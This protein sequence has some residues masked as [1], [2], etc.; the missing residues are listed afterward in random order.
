MRAPDFANIL[1]ILNRQ[2]PSRPTLFEFFLNPRLYGRMLGRKEIGSWGSV[3]HSRSV[4]AA[5]PRFGYDYATVLAC[6]L[7]FPTKPHDS[8]ASRS[9]NES[10]LICDRAS[11][12]AYPW[13][14]PDRFDYSR[15]ETLRGDMVPGMK[16]IVYGPGGVLENVMAIV[17]YEPIC[18]MLADDPGLAKDVFDAVG[19][20]LLRYYEIAAK[21]DAVGA[22]ISNDDW[23]F[24]SQPMLSPP[25]MREY[26]FPWHKKIVEVIHAAG[27][28]AILHSCGQ[29]DSLMDTIIDELK[30]DG[31]HSY[32]DKICPVEEAYERWGGRIAILGGL[33]LDFVC[34]HTPEQVRARA[35][36]MLERSAGRGS[37]AL[38]TGNSVPEYVPDE[39]YL[40]MIEPAVGRVSLG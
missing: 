9:M 7:G 19:S 35:Q 3:E 16:L 29:L 26:V 32:E 15:L 25:A 4:V 20:R 22:L 36:G 37:Y 2:K 39:N 10:A 24:A 6:E 1:R 30:F 11:F 17:G 28:P 38:G 40:A 31:K 12:E 34:R 23:G 14:D 8:Q 5:Y 21:F 13:P 27:K 18:L 33:D